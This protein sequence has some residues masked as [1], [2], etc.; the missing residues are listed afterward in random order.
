MARKSP[1]PDPLRRRHMLEEKLDPARALAI[2]QAYLADDRACE[3]VAFLAKA[4]AREALA[5]LRERA[6]AEGDPFLL[7]Q[8]CAALGE[9]PGADCWRR[10]AESARAAG[11]EVQARDADRQAQLG[12][13]GRV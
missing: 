7:R 6:V 3:A 12:E 2:A 5:E 4:D 9:E 13:T 10:L 8:S 11:K 1:I